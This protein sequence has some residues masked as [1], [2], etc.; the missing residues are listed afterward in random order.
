MNIKKIIILAILFSFACFFSY[1]N[2]KS[3]NAE[4]SDFSFVN[5]YEKFSYLINDSFSEIGKP[6]IG[7]FTTNITGITKY[8]LSQTQSQ[9]LFLFLAFLGVALL[10]TS[11]FII[12]PGIIQLV[13]AYQPQYYSGPYSYR[14][15]N[16]ADVGYNLWCAGVGFLT[17]GLVL[18]WVFGLPLTI[19]GF[20]FYS[21]YGGKFTIFMENKNKYARLGFDLKL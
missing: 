1:S 20:V 2:E 13:L 12:T 10:G 16:P 11:L 5:S 14:P 21:Y 9:K 15:F 19:I 7:P 18:F 6:D 3:V 17:A 4:K 8:N